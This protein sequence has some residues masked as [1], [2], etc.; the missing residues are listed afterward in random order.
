MDQYVRSQIMKQY[1]LAK[2]LEKVQTTTYCETIESIL[3]PEQRCLSVDQ[4]TIY[5]NILYPIKQQTQET[6]LTFVQDAIDSFNAS[7][8]GPP[9][10]YDRSLLCIDLIFFLIE[11][12]DDRFFQFLQGT[13]L[14]K[15]NSAGAGPSSY[16]DARKSSPVKP[17][18]IPL[19]EGMV[20][21]QP[22]PAPIPGVGV[23]VEAVIPVPPIGPAAALAAADR[24]AEIEIGEKCK[25]H[26]CG[27]GWSSIITGCGFWYSGTN[28]CATASSYYVPFLVS[29]A[30]FCLFITVAA[31]IR[32]IDRR[33]RRAALQ[34]PLVQSDH[35]TVVSDDGTDTSSQHSDSD[36]DHI[37]I[38]NEGNVHTI[39]LTRSDNQ[40]YRQIS[41]ATVDAV[42]SVETMDR[43]AGRR[44]YKTRR[45]RKKHAIQ[46]NKR[47][48]PRRRSTYRK[49]K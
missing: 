18:P 42:P 31:I 7:I 26:I 48:K 22:V 46:S 15:C 24:E 28:S 21:N 11:T 12:A 25:F 41:A 30:G 3:T 27:S 2:A 8:L 32:Q 4:Q 49:K 10:K 9:I 47:N 33:R 37:Q 1:M 14:T 13:M 44:R 20:E 40:V 34:L 17:P 6:A 38:E 29:I 19:A 45:L 35:G 36:S 5:P 23:A 43:V 16:G 39:D